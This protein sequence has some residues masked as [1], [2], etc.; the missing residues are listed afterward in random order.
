MDSLPLGLLAQ[1]VGA[2]VIVHQMRESPQ[3]DQAI[4]AAPGELTMIAVRRRDYRR[5]AYPYTTECASTISEKYRRFFPKHMTYTPYGCRQACIDAFT[6]SEC[7]CVQSAGTTDEH[8][9]LRYCDVFARTDLNCMHQIDDM[10]AAS[11]LDCDC[12]LPCAN[13]DYFVT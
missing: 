5:L 7:G 8:G 2:R 6:H 13:T 1:S 11:E 9:L 10:V 3:F 12:P 4:Y